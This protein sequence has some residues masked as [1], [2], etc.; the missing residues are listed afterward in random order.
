MSATAGT[1]HH[2]AINTIRTLAMDAVQAANSGHPGAPMGAAPLAYALWTRFLRHNPADPAWPDR[3]RFV[4]SAGHAS[5][6]LYALLHLTGYDLPLEELKRF[7]QWGSRTPGHPERGLTPGVEATTGPLGSGVA[8]AVGMASAE[9]MLAA[10]F[11]RPG[12]AVVDHR[13]W[14]LVSDG[15]LMEGVAAE[16]VSLAGALGLGKLTLLYDDN[17][18]TIDGGTGL[19]FA[20]D[21]GERF[22]ACGWHVQRIDGHDLDAIDAAIRAAL[23]EEERPSLIAAAT[24]IAHGSPNKAGTAAAHGAALGAEEVRLTKEALGWPVE[25]AFHVP[26]DA[27]AEFRAALNEGAARQDDW[28]ERLDAWAREHP[29]AA[30]EWRRVTAGELPDGW[31]AHVPTFTAEETPAMAT[32][33]ASGKVLNALAAALPELVG[34]SA[35]LASSTN[36]YLA[37]LGDFG[38]ESP[39]GRNLRFGVREHAMGGVLN[40]IALHGGLIPFGGT[41]LVFSDWMRGAMRLGAIMGCRAVCVFTHDSIG[42]GEDGPTHQPIEH[43]MALRAI[44][45][46][47][48]IRPAD[49]N[50]TAAAWKVALERDGPT[51]LA[52][53]RQSAP[54][55][56]KAA[57][58][59]AGVARGAYALDGDPARTPDVILIATG[60]EVALARAAAVRLEER[61]LAARVVSMP[62]WEL[63]AAQPRDYRD[64]VLPPGVAARLVVEAGVSLGW[65]RYAGDRGEIM[66]IDRFGASAPGAEMMARHGFTAGAVA[67]R[68]AALVE[69]L[70]AEG[71]GNP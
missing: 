15:D 31:D 49:A 58:A 30:A 18:I 6:L 7:R 69:R 19:A 44:P 52:L 25:P 40:G 3:D 4:L 71:A 47:T 70:R 53:T 38:R 33:Q 11:N 56:E 45:G 10:R 42:V 17:G 51:A 43:L 9:R 14:A 65:E 1:L 20:E 39:D 16:A 68:A 8:N 37:G 48:V 29:D 54:V 36:T 24:E 32:R 67:E 60:S 13:T 23:A 28:R 22:R 55:I 59:R 21:V 26:D 2:R 41:F 61:G 27:L 64:E 35:D 5:M 34:G 12:H 57:C 46:L 63:F 66:G 62:S 50:E